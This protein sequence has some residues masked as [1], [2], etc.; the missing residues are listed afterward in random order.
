MAWLNY[1]RLWWNHFSSLCKISKH[2]RHNPCSNHHSKDI[3]FDQITFLLK[4]GL[5]STHNYCTAYQSLINHSIDLFMWHEHPWVI[6][7][8][9]SSIVLWSNKLT[10]S[11][12]N[13]SCNRHLARNLLNLV[14]MDQFGLA[15]SG[16]VLL[17]LRMVQQIIGYFRWQQCPLA[18]PASA[19]KLIYTAAAGGDA[20]EDLCAVRPPKFHLSP[21]DTLFRRY[22]VVLSAIEN[23]SADRKKK[24]TRNK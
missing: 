13:L 5:Y 23:R 15:W 24:K 7:Y 10:L 1:Q 17:V 12:T 16:W 11:R 2:V 21:V 3:D 6:T 20:K 19:S 9:S 14:K 4:G 18:V 8:A 22:P